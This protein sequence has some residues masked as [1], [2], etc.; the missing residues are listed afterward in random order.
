MAVPLKEK[1]KTLILLLKEPKV[2]NALISFR[3]SGYLVET[4]W[5]ESFKMKEPVTF[6]FEPLP[7]MTYS[8]IK[9]IESRLTDQFEIF[10]YG[11]GNS[12][13]FFAPKIKSIMSVEHNEQWFK[14]IGKKLPANCNLLWREFPSEKYSQACKETGKKYD[15]VID[16]AMDR[17]KVIYNSL[18][19]LKESGVFVLDDSERTEYY[20]GIKFLLE[21]DYKKIDFWGLAPGISYNKCTTIFYKKENCLKI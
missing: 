15:I 21:N 3:H 10:E 18:N 11:C 9:F 13:S 8:F 16:D 4:G 5:M 2:L 17:V 1:I 6:D 14:K 7:W 20:D 12:T 19:S